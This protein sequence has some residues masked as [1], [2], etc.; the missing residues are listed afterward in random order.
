MYEVREYGRLLLA[1]IP[2]DFFKRERDSYC[3]KRQTETRTNQWTANLLRYLFYIMKTP[4]HGGRNLR[5][6]SGPHCLREGNR[7]FGGLVRFGFL[8]PSDLAF[9]FAPRAQTTAVDLPPSFDFRKRN[10]FSFKQVLLYVATG[11]KATH[12]ASHFFDSFHK[13]LVA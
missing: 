13:L 6:K 12:G 2:P 11:V 9:F 3:I 7:G 8:C 1:L 4:E 5:P 10:S